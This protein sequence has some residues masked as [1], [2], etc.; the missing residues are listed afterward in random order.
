MK[1]IFI[2]NKDKITNVFQLKLDKSCCEPKKIWLDKGSEFYHRSVKSW[3]L[4]KNIEIYLTANEE[5][6]DV[7]EIFTMILKSK[8]HKNRKS[9]KI[10]KK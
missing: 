4:D 2:A 1:L 5:K 7:A 3:L 10:H 8:I 9:K 6:S